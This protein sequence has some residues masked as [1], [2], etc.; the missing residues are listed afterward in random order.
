MS[1]FISYSHTDRE[2]VD[3][4]VSVLADRDIQVRRDQRLRGAGSIA[5][6]ILPLIRASSC[7]VFYASPSS[8]TSAWCLQEL[9]A[10]WA[11]GKPVLVFC[12]EGTS[13]EALPDTLRANLSFTSL[14]RLASAVEHAEKYERQAERSRRWQA[15]GNVAMPL[16]A[17]LGLAAVCLVLW[18]A[19]GLEAAST[20]MGQGADAFAKTVDRSALG[21]VTSETLIVGSGSVLE[22]LAAHGFRP[23]QDY[24][25]YGKGSSEKPFAALLGGTTRGL[26]VEGGS[27]T[28]LLFLKAA[29][30]EG[31]G[32]ADRAFPVLALASLPPEK[33]EKALF[34]TGAGTS[35][36]FYS[37]L[38]ESHLT[39]S[40]GSRNDGAE[41]F[42]ALTRLLANPEVDV[43]TLHDVLSECV[44]IKPVC[45]CF[46]PPPES[47]TRLLL[48]DILGEGQAV[49]KECKQAELRKE[50]PKFTPSTKVWL[51]LGNEVL[52]Q[53][54]FD[55]DSELGREQDFSMKQLRIAGA[56]T[57]PLSIIGRY[58]GGFDQKAEWGTLTEP[59]C[60]TLK[61]VRDVFAGESGAK[62]ASAPLGGLRDDCSVRGSRSSE[63]PQLNNLDGQP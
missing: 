13:A 15:L 22:R 59:L 28:A 58:P 23:A 38:G 48:N 6:E 61:T 62:V 46:T 57:Q 24:L 54:T 5:H 12:P 16:T 10:C 50:L 30:N 21:L 40:V 51:A 56:A 1:V 52:Y 53:R 34:T 19:R 43:P 25:D 39:V 49:F 47:G 60:T 32:S 11:L 45:Q 29:H 9:G 7:C 8:L 36:Y 41:G 63:H 17:A 35:D 31:L 33:I 26:F 14:D 42:P 44:A 55:G 3:R 2:P 18:V 27:S 20:R 37:V 4:L